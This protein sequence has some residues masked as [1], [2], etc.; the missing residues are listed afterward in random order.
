MAVETATTASA[1]PVKTLEATAARQRPR[2]RDQWGGGCVPGRGGAPATATPV[3][4]RASGKP[5][6][7][8]WAGLM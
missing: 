2:R 8:F 4:G 3:A 1:A 7:R 5:R 6:Q